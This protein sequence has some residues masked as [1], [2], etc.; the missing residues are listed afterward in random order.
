MSGGS[1]A[2]I[3]K[4]EEELK[5]GDTHEFI[6]ISYE[7]IETCYKV[8]NVS[9]YHMTDYKAVTTETKY[10]VEAGKKCNFKRMDES[11]GVKGEDG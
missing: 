7:K 5:A 3:K 11:M 6:I 8:V 1:L 10:F 2:N 9:V 4:Y